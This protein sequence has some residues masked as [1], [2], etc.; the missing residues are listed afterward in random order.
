M[1]TSTPVWTDAGTAVIA[2][3]ALARGSTARGTFDNGTATA[4]LRT[5]LIVLI[6]RTGTTALTN[7]VD[8]AIRP[9]LNNAAISPGSTPQFKTGAAAA[10]LATVSTDS[11]VD[12]PVLQVDTI[13]GY[14]AGDICLIGAGTAREE[15]KRV[16]KTDAG[17]VDLVFDSPLEFAHTLAQADKVHNQGSVFEWGVDEG[18]QHEVVADYGAQAA[19]ESVQVHVMKKTLDSVLSV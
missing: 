12:Q 17:N 11:A 10:S 2:S 16:S 18:G 13:S 14:A 15:W 9:M 1:A 7:G 5:V 4:K 19:G 8:V 6:G 3:A